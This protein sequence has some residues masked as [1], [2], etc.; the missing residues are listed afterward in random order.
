[1]AEI[2]YV[3][4]EINLTYSGVVKLKEIY[5]LIRSWFSERGFFV[6]EKE[7]EGSEDDAGSNFYTKFEASKRIEEYTKYKIEIKIK[8]KFL[9]ETSEQ[10]EYQGDYNISF[11][12]YLEKDYEDKYENKP[13]LKIFKGF[14]EKLVEKSRFNKYENE[15]RD[16]TNSIYNEVKAFLNLSKLW[17][18]SGLDAILIKLHRNQLSILL[19]L[20]YN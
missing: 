12:S 9:K 13:I 5:E 16:D 6:I 18:F 20:S 17:D 14:Y 4:H 2:D 1:M 10:Y 19:I 15:L 3:V 11:E 8:A 7:S